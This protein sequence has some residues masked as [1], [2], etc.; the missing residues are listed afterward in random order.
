MQRESGLC[1]FWELLAYDKDLLMVGLRTASF[2]LRGG[3]KFITRHTPWN[4]IPEFKLTR[5]VEGG[6]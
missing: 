4:S 1:I 2:A 3:N 5:Q 6:S